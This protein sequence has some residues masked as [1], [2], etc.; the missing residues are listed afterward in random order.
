MT[1]TLVI[2]EHA[3]GKLNS[4]L[5]K[6]LAAAKAI[7]DEIDVAIFS[8]NGASIAEEVAIHDG[9]T[10]VLQID[11][12]ENCH[13]LAAIIAPQVIEV[14][15]R[16]YTHLL[17]PGSVF[18]KDLLPRV[19]AKL[20]VQ[21]VSDVMAIRSPTCFDRL[22]YAGNA[23][24]TVEAP[25]DP[26]VTATVR[27]ASFAPVSRDRQYAAPIELVSCRAQ[28]PSHTVFVRLDQHMSARPDLQSASRVVAGGRALG[29][30]ENFKMICEL[31]D[32]IQAAVGAT[33]A[34]V[35]S[36]YAPNEMQV[37]QTGKIIAPELYIAVGI[38]GAVQHLAGI[39]D[40]GTIVAINSD[41][42]AP[43]FS[44]A[45]YGL[46]GDLFEIVPELERKL[47]NLHG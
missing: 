14:F 40:A 37:G 28:L 26:C 10:R 27:M 1:K 43:I 31:A 35:D 16:G 13:P 23:M 36:G 21:Q 38:S 15:Q 24:V 30:V 20:G 44:V 22:I 5:A 12:A 33:R 3:G 32:K 42:D 17:A 41:P 7:G 9:V 29:S 34:A 18:G 46:V 19:S 47:S 25:A 4:G 6:V 45:D 8:D 39:K 2:A 11:R